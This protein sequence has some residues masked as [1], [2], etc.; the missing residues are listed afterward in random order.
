[1]IRK[2]AKLIAAIAEA[3][4]PLANSHAWPEIVARLQAAGCSAK[5]AHELRGR[6]WLAR[7]VRKASIAVQ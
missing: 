6:V 1:V 5:V 2:S 3:T 7:K 4:V